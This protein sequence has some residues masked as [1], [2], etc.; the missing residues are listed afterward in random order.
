MRELPQ[1]VEEFDVFRGWHWFYRFQMAA[2]TVDGFRRRMWHMARLRLRD[3]AETPWNGPAEAPTWTVPDPQA[4][5]GLRPARIK[6]VITSER[7]M[8]LVYR[9]HI[10]LP[11]L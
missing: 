2:R 5:G 9:W 1:V 8:A 6:D 4:P 3:I 7:G 11:V 10:S